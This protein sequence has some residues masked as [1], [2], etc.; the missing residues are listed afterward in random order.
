MEVVHRVGHLQAN[1]VFRVRSPDGREPLLDRLH[2]IAVILIDGR[3]PRNGK[4][5]LVVFERKT[6]DLV[7]Q[8]RA[9]KIFR[10]EQRAILVEE[11]RSC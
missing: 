3:L 8:G 6:T 4:I 5:E 11:L 9:R 7:Q 10:G 2:G 1:T